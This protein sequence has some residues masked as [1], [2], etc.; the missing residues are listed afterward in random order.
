MFLIGSAPI[1]SPIVAPHRTYP[2]YHGL[3]LSSS[4][5]Y[6]YLSWIALNRIVN[7]NSSLNLD[8]IQ[9]LNLITDL[10]PGLTL[11]LTPQLVGGGLKR[12]VVAQEEIVDARM[13]HLAHWRPLSIQPLPLPKQIVPFYKILPSLRPEKWEKAES[14]SSCGGQQRISPKKLRRQLR[15]KEQMQ[16]QLKAEDQKV[17]LLYSSQSQ[18]TSESNEFLISSPSLSQ[19]KVF[20]LGLRSCWSGWGPI[21]AS[22]KLQSCLDNPHKSGL[23]FNVFDAHSDKQVILNNLS[24]GAKRILDSPNAGGR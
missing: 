23:I 13:Q 3:A 19:P 8:H 18:I 7:Q 11:E 4:S 12:P 2:P 20:V 16:A 22:F 10:N 5:M 17:S 14:Q 15:Q 24:K 21:S 1:M 6:L 9:N